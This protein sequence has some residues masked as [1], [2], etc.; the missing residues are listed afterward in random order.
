MW[1][2]THFHLKSRET[3]CH[4][5]SERKV[6]TFNIFLLHQGMFRDKKKIFFFL[7]CFFFFQFSGS[8][9]SVS[10]HC[11]PS[12][13]AHLL[14]G[15]CFQMSVCASCV[16][17]CVWAGVKQEMVCTSWPPL[18]PPPV[19]RG[20]TLSGGVSRGC[21]LHNTSALSHDSQKEIKCGFCDREGEGSRTESTL[22]PP[23]VV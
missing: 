7:F 10:L 8:A 21:G 5:S 18:P 4:S 3:L 13:P 23:T 6:L 12:D 22:S 1:T 20:G 15:R 19:A 9:S 2:N 17:V 14:A 11:T 16:T